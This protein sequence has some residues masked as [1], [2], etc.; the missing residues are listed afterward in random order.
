MDKLKEYWPQIVG[1]I[2]I[3]TPLLGWVGNNIIEGQQAKGYNKAKNE[4]NESYND[5]L[6]DAIVYR[7]KYESCCSDI[8]E[9]E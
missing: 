9:T 4:I 6:R 1:T 2:G 5:A 8:S 7:A 3:L